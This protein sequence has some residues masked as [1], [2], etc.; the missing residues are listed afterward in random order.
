MKYAKIIIIVPCF[1]ESER[2]DMDK[3]CEF[4]KKFTFVFVNDGSTDNTLEILNKYKSDYIDVIDLNENCGKGE[5]VRQGMLKALEKYRDAVWYGYIDAD[6]A[7]SL[8]E[9]DQFFLYSKTFYPEA[10]GILGSRVNKLGSNINRLYFR[11][12]IGRLFAIFFKISF[13]LNTYDSQCGAKFFKKEV[14]NEAFSKAFQASW[15]FDVEIII[16][17]R[18]FLLIEYPLKNWEDKKGS[19]LM[20][21]SSAFTVIKDII[22]LKL[23]Y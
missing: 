11:H 12:L 2:L 10:Q 17:L 1:N 3:F 23:K 20:S 16:R 18:K 6:L 9:I 15:L 22:T 7:V 4:S 5:A 19:K 21:L 13:N 8:E 14:V